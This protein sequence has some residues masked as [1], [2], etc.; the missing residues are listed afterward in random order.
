MN[1]GR[2]DGVWY[3]AT[4]LKGSDGDAP[5]LWCDQNDAKYD[6][7]TTAFWWEPGIAVDMRFRAKHGPD[8]PDI[9]QETMHV[10]SLL[11]KG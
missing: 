2:R 11:K 4:K 1:D 6:R 8:W 3:V 10:L 9:Y 5:V 7:C